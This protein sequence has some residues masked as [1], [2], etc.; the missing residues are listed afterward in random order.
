[1]ITQPSPK[2]TRNLYFF[3]VVGG[4]PV[5]GDEEDVLG[6]EV[7]VGE[8]ALVQELDG[9]DQL[10]RDVPHLL[11]RVRMVVVLFLKRKNIILFVSLS[12]LAS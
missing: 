4:L 6:L 5:G 11:Q 9:V 2:L 3:R 1:M 7:G 8:L 12:M 10:V